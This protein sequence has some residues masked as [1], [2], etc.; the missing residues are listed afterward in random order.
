MKKMNKMIGSITAKFAVASCRSS[1]VRGIAQA[2][3]VC[4]KEVAYV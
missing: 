2:A 4:R 1:S 3:D